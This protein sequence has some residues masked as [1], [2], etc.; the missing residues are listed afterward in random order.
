LKGTIL[1]LKTKNPKTEE[2]ILQ[3]KLTTVTHKVHQSCSRSFSG[4]FNPCEKRQRGNFV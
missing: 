4:L 2:V 3:S 1:G